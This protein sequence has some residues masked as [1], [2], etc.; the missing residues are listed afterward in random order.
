MEKP[1]S[2]STV[3]GVGAARFGDLVYVIGRDRSLDQQHVE[4]SRLI[5]FDGGKFGH[6]GD[7]NWTAT[8]I[9]IAKRPSE[10]MVVV[11]EEG[12]VFTYAAGK[13]TEE[14]LTPTPSVIR[15]AGVVDGLVYACGMKRQVYRRDEEG[16]WTDI[17]A[18]APAPGTN[19]GFEAIG[20]FAAT[21]VYAAGWAGEIWRWNGAAWTS[22]G[23]LTNY[24]LT[25]LCTTDNDVV[26]CGQ[27]GSLLRGRG[28]QWDLV[29][30][31]DFAEDLWDVAWYKGQLYMSSMTDLFVL[32]DDGLQ[33]VDFGADRPATFYRLTQ[34]EGVLWSIGASDIFC[35]DGSA[36]KRID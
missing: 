24:I 28:Q 26:I 12:A 7:R 33:S 20:G 8:A 1:I 11:S 2:K 4:H 10:R 6:M 22:L 16:R 35:F 15:S 14:Q 36:W 17:S 31:G 9:A 27:G 19:A 25:A 13:H 29:D 32:T 3:F 30:L 5:G 21:E 23:S 18:P 34:A